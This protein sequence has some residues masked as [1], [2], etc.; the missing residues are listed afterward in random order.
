MTVIVKCVRLTAAA[1]RSTSN[2]VSQAHVDQ[3]KRCIYLTADFRIEKHRLAFLDH[4][5][6]FLF[7]D[8]GL[9][10]APTFN[11]YLGESMCNYAWKCV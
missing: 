8:F 2:F 3:I 7:A 5:S 4:D 11:D 6:L 9:R 1:A 10:G